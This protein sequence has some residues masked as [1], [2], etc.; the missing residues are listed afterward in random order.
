[1]A[2][3]RVRRARTVAPKPLTEREGVGT[4]GERSG[5]AV[6]EKEPSDFGKYDSRNRKIYDC[7]G[8]ERDGNP[9]EGAQRRTVIVPN[10]D[11]LSLL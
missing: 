7:Q 6:P 10:L 8:M 11:N 5:T 1:M 9:R 3:R 4:R 2:N